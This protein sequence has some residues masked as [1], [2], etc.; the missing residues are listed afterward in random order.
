M[1]NPDNKEGMKTVTKVRAL[2]ELGDYDLAIK[3]FEEVRVGFLNQ[4]AKATLNFYNAENNSYISLFTSGLNKPADVSE[5]QF[6]DTLVKAF[7]KINPHIVQVNIFPNGNNIYIARV[8]LSTEEAGRDFIVDYDHKRDILVQHY[9]SRDNIRFNINVDD[10][11]MKKIKQYEKKAVQITS[12]IKNEGDIAKDMQGNRPAH[13]MPINNM[14]HHQMGMMNMPPNKLPFGQPPMP[15]T[16]YP[17]VNQMEMPP[18]NFPMMSMRAGMGPMGGAMGSGMGTGMVGGGM[19]NIPLGNMP[20]SAMMNPAM[21]SKNP[22][23]EFRDKIEKMYGRKTQIVDSAKGDKEYEENS[24][25][26]WLPIVKFVL[27]ADLKVSQLESMNQAST[28][29]F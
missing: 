7:R 15:N 27:E 22:S 25:R 3:N 18:N 13:R 2:V 10:K 17:M 4:T 19:G 24:R 9:K 20:I 28:I 1:P 14:M 23:V 5:K 12:K 26:Q 29:L 6:E 11:T 21:G 8:Y 16:G